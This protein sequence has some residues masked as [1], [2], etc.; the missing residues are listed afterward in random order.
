MEFNE[1]IADFATRHSVEDLIV[2]DGV[3][4]LD[5]DGIIV[6]IV[7][8]GEKII[9]SADIGEP[10]AEGSGVFANLLLE[11]NLQSDEF[12]AKD[13]GT[14]CLCHHAAVHAL[15]TRPRYF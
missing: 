3:T 1:L 11:T 14:R 7:S 4:A 6:S 12:F 5:I 8:N 2:E 10:P 15:C 13:G 9:F